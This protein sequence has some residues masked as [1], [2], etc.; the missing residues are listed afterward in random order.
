[1]QRYSASCT[2]IPYQAGTVN[3]V[4][5]NETSKI[6]VALYYAGMVNHATR[7]KMIKIT[8][9]TF[10]VWLEHW[11]PL[12]IQTKT[13]RIIHLAGKTPNKNSYMWSPFITQLKF[14]LL[15]TEQMQFMLYSLQ[16]Q[17]SLR[18]IPQCCQHLSSI[19]NW[20]KIFRLAQGESSMLQGRS[21]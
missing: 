12:I 7:N 3:H 17:C 11:T 16:V 10:I 8:N 2:N 21:Q 1:M 18:L 6:M 14:Y 19:A 13:E 9:T 15:C 4:T 5:N 20:V